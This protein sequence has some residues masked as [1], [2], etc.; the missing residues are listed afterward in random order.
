[1]DIEELLERYA[2]GER[3]FSGVDLSR[4]DLTGVDFS[5]NKLNNS[6]C[7]MEADF[8]NSNLSK[9]NLYFAIFEG[10]NLKNANLTGAILSCANFEGA[11]LTNADLTCSELTAT[12]FAAAD[13]T[14]ANLSNS[15]GSF[16]CK[17]TF[18]YNTIM[19]NNTI[20]SG[21]C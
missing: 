7:F 17:D 4:T 1:M 2:A 3:D 16:M 15:Q 19:P 12:C 14:N 20:K 11:N 21:E 18:F 6:I 5:S 13:L 10:A 9:A 8:C